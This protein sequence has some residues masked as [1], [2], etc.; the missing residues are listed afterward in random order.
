MLG[1]VSE[2]QGARGGTERRDAMYGMP[3]IYC[4]TC[5]A[6][7]AIQDWRERRESFLIELHPCGHVVLRTA[8]LEW[9]SRRAAA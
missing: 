9:M 6:L 1:H 2:W 4:S 3:A 8:R 7:R 5:Q